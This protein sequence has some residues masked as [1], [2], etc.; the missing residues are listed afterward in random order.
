M[1]DLAESFRLPLANVDLRAFSVI[2]DQEVGAFEVWRDFFDSLHVHDN[3][4]PGS[5]EWRIGQARLQVVELVIAPKRLVRSLDLDQSILDPDQD[6]LIQL[7][8]HK[9]VPASPYKLMNRRSSR[10]R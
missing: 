2:Q 3:R 10:C 5:K 7:Y 6:D 1:Q 4:A 9:P 8:K